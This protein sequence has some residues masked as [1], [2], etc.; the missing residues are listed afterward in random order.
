MLALGI[1]LGVWCCAGVGYALAGA[2]WQVGVSGG[3]VL[4]IVGVLLWLRGPVEELLP[5]LFVLDLLENAWGLLANAGGG[6]WAR[7]SVEWADAA[8]RWRDDYHKLLDHT[9]ALLDANSDAPLPV[10]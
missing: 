7:E 9:K 6:D 1:C 10:P 2:W 8:G 5:A 3:V 4:G